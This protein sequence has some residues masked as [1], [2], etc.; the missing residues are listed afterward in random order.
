M[1]AIAQAEG[2]AERL[3]DE[4]DEL[5]A[6]TTGQVFVQAITCDDCGTTIDPVSRQTLA[7]KWDDHRMKFGCRTFGLWVQIGFE[8]HEE[9]E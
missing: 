1:N 6:E 7:K 4:L 2:E 5:N 9:D 8:D 3:A